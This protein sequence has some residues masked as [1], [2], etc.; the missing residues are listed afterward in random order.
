RIE[1]VNGPRGGADKRVEIKVVLSGLP[2]VVVTEQHR[3]L[4]A[5]TDRAL[6]R[7]ERAVRRAL[8]RRRTRATRVRGTRLPAAA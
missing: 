8:Q 4:Q 2:S 1:D 3:S 6:D 7:A 5:A